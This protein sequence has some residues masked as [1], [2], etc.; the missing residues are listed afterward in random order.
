MPARSRR[1]ATELPVNASARGSSSCVS[2]IP[3]TLPFRARR[4]ADAEISRTPSFGTE[5]ARDT[6]AVGA[7]SAGATVL[8]ASPIVVGLVVELVVELVVDVELVVELVLELG[9]TISGA[10]LLGTNSDF[11]IAEL[12]VVVVG[13][14]VVV[15]LGLAGV[16]VVVVL[17]VG[18]AAASQDAVSDGCGSSAS[19]TRRL[20]MS[21][22]VT[23]ERPFGPN[24]SSQT[25]TGRY[26]RSTGRHRQ[27]GCAR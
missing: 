20:S 12:V 4:F 2:S 18:V 27:H 3:R 8:V 21:L 22:S 17:V 10:G 16:M 6:S 5:V 14:V 25:A 15:V 9:G 13:S 11:G 1:V 24:N 7:A 19:K 26:P 23:S